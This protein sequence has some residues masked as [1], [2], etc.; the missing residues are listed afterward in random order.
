MESTKSILVQVSETIQGKK[1]TLEEVVEFTD[2]IAEK[3]DSAID[4]VDEA[5]A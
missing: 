1:F 2:L 5:W 4:K 3:L